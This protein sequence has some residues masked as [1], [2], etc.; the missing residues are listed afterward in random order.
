MAHHELAHA[1]LTDIDTQ[2]DPFAV[3]SRGTPGRAFS[4][5]PAD[6]IANLFRNARASGLAVPDLP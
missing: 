6:Q 1:G 5:H 4:A 2:Q 3:D